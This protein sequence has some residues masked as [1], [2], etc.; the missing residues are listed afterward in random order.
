MFRLKIFLALSKKELKHYLN[1]PASYLS[2]VVFLF[3]WEFLFFRNVFLI[4][5]VSLRILYDYLPWI[6]LFFLPAVSM[7]TFS[8]E[9]NDGTYELLLTQPVKP[10]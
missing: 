6:M 4:G 3:I 10:L 2:L 1:N 9:K 5:E 7:G 8:Q